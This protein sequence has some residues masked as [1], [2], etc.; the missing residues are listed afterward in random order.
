MANYNV[1]NYEV[2]G[3]LRA[4]LL[5]LDEELKH[6]HIT[7][8]FFIQRL[9]AQID[10]YTAQL[11]NGWGYA[12]I[13]AET[14]SSDIT[15]VKDDI[16]NMKKQAATKTGVTKNLAKKF[17]NDLD[18]YKKDV[19]QLKCYY[20]SQGHKPPSDSISYMINHLCGN[21]KL[22][23]FTKTGSGKTIQELINSGDFNGLS[24]GLDGLAKED[25]KT[26]TYPI[27]SWENGDDVDV[28]SLS[29]LLKEATGVILSDLKNLQKDF[30]KMQDDV[31]NNKDHK[32][33][34]QDAKQ[35][36]A[37]FA[38]YKQ[39]VD[40]HAPDPYTADC[41]RYA[42]YIGGSITGQG[43]KTKTGETIDQLLASGNDQAL[44]NGLTGLATD[45]ASGQNWMD[46]WENGLSAEGTDS[47]SAET[48]D[49]DKAGQRKL[50]EFETKIN[51]F[52]NIASNCI[53]NISTFLTDAV[54]NQNV[55]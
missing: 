41:Q 4:E 55:S 32:V 18:K 43:L 52:N 26:Q 45:D 7:V 23:E 46:T 35:F 2:Y 30:Q 40:Q 5:Q 22:I 42:E 9:L 3:S 24:Y 49:L 29:E 10:G 47:T 8:W 11:K 34:E 1:A 17:A 31:K 6:K 12:T 25:T 28:Q 27:D 37:D 33:S 14:I 51:S 36:K 20:G 15:N 44:A 39:D 50:N 53:K 16:A 54:R 38:K 13:A 19:A 48:G 21:I